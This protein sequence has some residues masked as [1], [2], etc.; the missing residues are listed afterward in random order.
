MYFLNSVAEDEGG[1]EISLRPELTASISR[2]FN[3]QLRSQPLP[4]R[5]YYI[6]PAFR[7]DR[8]QYGRFREFTH[9]GVELIGASGPEADAEVIALARDITEA[10]GIYKYKILTD[11]F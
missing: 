3:A 9:V 11:W 2:V 4:L 7:H 1:D 10:L 5:L 8:P 6:G